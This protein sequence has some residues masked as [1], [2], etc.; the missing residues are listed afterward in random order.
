MNNPKFD[1]DN[2][3]SVLPRIV[4]PK[5]Q[6]TKES[7][8][9]SLDKKTNV[10]KN[11]EQISI[12]KLMKFSLIIIKIIYKIHLVLIYFMNIDILF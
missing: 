12:K 6:F 11:N 4:D 5:M 7:I 3:V 9:Q 8:E 10:C 2:Y 1:E